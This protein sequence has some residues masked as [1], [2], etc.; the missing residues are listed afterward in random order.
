MPKKKKKSHTQ[1]N[2]YVVWQF[3]FVHEVA[4]ISL[5]S[6]K[7]KYKVQVGSKPPLYG[8]SLSKSPI[9]N[10]ATLFGSG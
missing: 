8:L 7:K 3:A 2:I 6:R 4:R 10:H 1:D 5:L 9:K